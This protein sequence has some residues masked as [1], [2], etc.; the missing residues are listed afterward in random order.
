[1]YCEK[2]GNSGE[3]F[4]I[5]TYKVCL[6]LVDDSSGMILLLLYSFVLVSIY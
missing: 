4:I 3:S 6:Q 1:M 2:A 5:F